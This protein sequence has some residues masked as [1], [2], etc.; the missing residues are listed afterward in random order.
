MRRKKGEGN[1][2]IVV[3]L[4]VVLSLALVG[5]AFPFS[6]EEKEV[7]T[8]ETN[9]DVNNDYHTIIYKDKKYVYNSQITSVLYAGVDSSEELVTSNRY[10][11]A[12][13]AD[14]IELVILDNYHK[15]IKVLAVSRDTIT[16]VE[17]FTMNGNSRGTYETQ[18]GYAYA[19]G[20]GG[21]N[22]CSNLNAAVSHLLGGIPIHE[23][24]ITN[25]GS[26]KHLNQMVGGVSVTVPNDDLKEE[27]PELKKNAEVTL[28]DT[29]VEDFVRWRDTSIPFTNNGRMERQ[30]AFSSSFLQIFRQ[31]ISKDAES[32]WEKIESMGPYLQTSITKSQYLSLTEL[33]NKL[34]YSEQD[35]YTLEGENVQGEQFDE[36]HLNE[37]SLLETIVE[38]FYLEDGEVEE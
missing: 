11:I 13:R 12:P 33:L 8:V 29:N 3:F 6:Q 15:K 20:D 30:Q 23:Y 26:V 5:C 17:R 32:V 16:T 24:A 9:A 14:S 31:E 2:W 27:Y 35:Y 21:K 36:V 7:D 25:N 18:L 37:D 22:S 28:D 19:Y 1:H 10:S 34:D 4:I 38:L